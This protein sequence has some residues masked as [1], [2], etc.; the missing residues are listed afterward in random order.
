ME[1]CLAPVGTI[2]LTPDGDHLS[3]A[4]PGGKLDFY[5]ESDSDFFAKGTNVQITFVRNA[6]GEV[7]RAIMFSEG[8][9]FNAPKVR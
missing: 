4:F 5:P 6:R 2:T 9:P 8:A 7:S 3:A 1:T